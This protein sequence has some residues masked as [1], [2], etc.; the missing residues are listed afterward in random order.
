MTTKTWLSA[1]LA[2]A[3]VLAA[4]HAHSQEQNLD[5]IQLGGFS[6]RLGMSQEDVLRK[7]AVGYDVRHLDASSGTWVV[8]QKGLGGR[9]KPAIDRQLKTGH[10]R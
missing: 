3:L 8:T 2:L 4:S 6:L 1:G 7:L 5:E 9:S 10:S